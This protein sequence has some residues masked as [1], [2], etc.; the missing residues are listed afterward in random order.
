MHPYESPNFATP[1]STNPIMSDNTLAA[2]TLLQGKTYRYEI[3]K[4]LGQG[5]FGITYL[6]GRLH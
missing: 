1:S 5:S 3:R 4:V 6:A 2:G